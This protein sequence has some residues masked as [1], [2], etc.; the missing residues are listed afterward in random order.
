MGKRHTLVH[1]IEDWAERTPDRPAL[2]ARLPGGGWQSVSWKQYWQAVREV[3]NGL[4]ALGVHPGECVS[5]VGP[6]C[7]E[8]VQAEFGIQA[9]RGIVAPIYVTNTAEQTG[10][11]MGHCRARIVFCD[12]QEQL[13]KLVDCER[14]GQIPRL[15]HIV[16]FHDLGANDPRVK[17]F[18]ALRELGKSQSGPELDRRLDAMADTDTCILIYTSGT[19]GVPKAVQLT[20][21]G[22]L[23]ISP[24]ITDLKPELAPEG[25]YR[26]VSYLPLCH[27]AEQ[28]FTNLFS[29][30][31]G[32]QV[33]FCPDLTQIKD[34][35]L[36]VRPTVFL[37]V[38][39]VWEKFE[40]ALRAR[41]E[42]QKGLRGR[43]ARW[44]LATELSCFEREVNE[45]RPVNS[46]RRRIARALV[47]DKVKR[48]IGLDRLVVAVTGSAPIGVSTQ[49]FF[50]SLGV[51]LYEGY[52][53]S[54][55]SG[56][57]TV[58]DMKRPRFG[59][60]GKALRNVEIKIAEDGEILIGGVTL[61]P[62]Y[63]HMPEETK[64][65]F[66]TDGWLRSGDLGS[67]DGEGNLRIT[68]RKKE[69]IITAGG[70]NVGPVE[71]ENLIKTIVGVGQVVVVGDRKPYLVALVS[72]NP[73]AVVELAQA[74]GTEPGSVAELSLKPEVR[75]Y[76]ERQIEVAC[77]AKVA[78]Y[79]TIKK[80]AVLPHELTVEG[81]ELTPTM[82]LRRSVIT[83][84]YEDTIEKLY[85]S[86]ATKRSSASSPTP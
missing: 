13:D 10:Y 59:T 26:L 77:N 63:L 79:Q 56:V 24:S 21:R 6:N 41:V 27:Q 40:A 25:R 5:I 76:L 72:L 16:T 7:P 54:E 86:D 64:E 2:H 71:M 43:L 62:G 38:P 49:R 60:V 31:V 55:G 36:E 75:A 14:R 48:A 52:G 30:E 67:F 47:I 23:A 29:L 28:L 9:A 18:A 51:C 19:T 68:G 20:A 4:I 45:N 44:A 74:A 65:I 37:G 58:T 35:L 11:I 84:K 1:R 34:Y 80:I 33:F 73:E 8:W 32:G 39:R 12:N 57:S 83:A 81:G 17:T 78:P 3:G 22:Q 70:K 50:A 53:L 61:M 42:G 85:A 15:L 46:L 69:L 82:K 66:T